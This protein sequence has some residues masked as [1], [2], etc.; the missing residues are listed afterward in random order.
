MF[1]RAHWGNGY[2]TEAARAVRNWA[3]A[4]GGESL[5]SLIHP[6]NVRSQRV[7]A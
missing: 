6:A 4:Q 3:Y 5:I 1:A 7:A 2:A